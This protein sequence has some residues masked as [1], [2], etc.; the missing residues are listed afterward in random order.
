MI[1]GY[2]IQPSDRP[3]HASTSVRKTMRMLALETPWRMGRAPIGEIQIAV[4][5]RTSNSQNAGRKTEE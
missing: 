5:W 3:M 2:Y 1:D 4:Q